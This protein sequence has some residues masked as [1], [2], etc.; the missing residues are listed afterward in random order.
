MRDENNLNVSLLLNELKRANKEMETVINTINQISSQANLLALNSA[1]EAARAGEAGRGFSVV[2]DEI[3]R[4]ADQSLATNKSSKTLITNIQ[5][6]ANQVI[7]VRTVDVAFDTIDKI[8]RNLFE[9]NCD[10]QA[11]ATFDAVI[12][13]LKE[14]DNQFKLNQANIFLKNI[15]DIYEVY[16][17]LIIAD[18]DG[19]ILA[20]GSN[21]SIVGGDISH[22]D[23]FTETI[24]IN[25]VFVNDMH[26]SQLAKGF[27]M[28]YSAP[29]KDENNNII[30]VFSTRF[31]WDFIY[32]IIDSVK[33]DET[34]ELYLINKEGVVIG[35]RDR[36]GILEKDI[37]Y[38]QAVRRIKAGENRG[39]VIEKQGRKEII[40]AYCKTKG[41]NAYKGMEWSVIVGEILE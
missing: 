40:Y 16:T 32:D 31:N 25:G 24:K 18:M 29:V 21:P 5:E 33:I 26:Y 20:S 22:R 7:A 36:A 13:A 6:K 4:F 34:T 28:N 17:D 19:K 11:W 30:G 35:S 38:L 37:S 10:V 27:V 39:Y 3:K 9:R 15:I 1:I 2:A 12:Q 14:P 8:D 23:W 41:Y